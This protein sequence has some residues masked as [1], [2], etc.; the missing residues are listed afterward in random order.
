MQSGRAG[1]GCRAKHAA[2]ARFKLQTHKTVK[3]PMKFRGNCY[4]SYYILLATNAL[5]FLLSHFLTEV[6]T[7]TWSLYQKLGH[8][9]EKNFVVRQNRSSVMIFADK[10]CNKGL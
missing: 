10:Y 5:T 6:S 1:A 4:T 8:L 2:A 3:V 9:F 7:S